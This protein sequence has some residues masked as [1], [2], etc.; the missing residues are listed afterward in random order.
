M[1]SPEAIGLW[2]EIKLDIVREYSAAYTTILK[3]QS[4]CRG[5]AYIDAFAG[6]GQFVS[7]E[8]RTRLIPGSPLNALN[9]EHKFTEYH[10]IDIESSKIENLRNLIADRPEA[11]QVRFYTGD[12]NRVLREEVLGQFPYASYKRALCILDPYGVDIEWTTIEAIAKAKTMDLYLNFPLMDINRNEALKRLETA[13]LSQGARLTKIWGDSSWK[14]LAYIEQK[15]LFA[16]P[17]LIKIRGNETLKQEFVERLKKKAKFAYVP[18]PILMSNQQGGPLYFLFF[19]SHQ[20]VAEKIAQDIFEKYRG[21][22]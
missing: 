15:D 13:D 4:W 17:V 5:Y 3:E 14:D 10:F 19:A 7:K 1:S 20:R 6:P 9:I 2:T 11:E 16:S 21:A 8:N 12:A 22:S 18:E